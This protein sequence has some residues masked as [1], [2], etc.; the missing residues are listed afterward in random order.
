MLG[1]HQ[2]IILVDEE[3]ESFFWGRRGDSRVGLEHGNR[4]DVRLLE[5]EGLDDN[6]SNEEEEVLVAHCCY[7]KV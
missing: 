2:H 6:D 5:V 4:E 1:W 3:G 7:Q